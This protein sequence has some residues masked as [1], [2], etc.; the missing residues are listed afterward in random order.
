MAGRAINKETIKRNT[1]R[2]MENLGVYKPEYDAIID[3]YCEL[4]EQYERLTDK[5]KKTGYEYSEET[6]RG[7]TKKSTLLS[8]LETIRRDL[9]AY[10]DRLCLNP[11]AL[12][13]KKVNESQKKDKVSVLGRALAEIEKG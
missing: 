1:V 9:L 4:R 13:E 12:S 5:Y 11:K 3:V 7:G 10:S 6:D 8:A 2:D